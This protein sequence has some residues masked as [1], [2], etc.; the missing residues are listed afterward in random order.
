MS[1]SEVVFS[2][3]DSIFWFTQLA[4]CAPE[5]LGAAGAPGDRT[6][7]GD[8]PPSGA[9]SLSAFWATSERVR[10]TGPTS[11]GGAC[12]LM[13]LEAAAPLRQ[14]RGGWLPCDV[15]R[16]VDAHPDHRGRLAL[17]G[18]LEGEGLGAGGSADRRQLGA[19]GVLDA[20]DG[21]GLQAVG[22]DGDAWSP[23]ASMAIAALP[24]V[25]TAGSAPCRRPG[26]R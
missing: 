14:R 19:D 18:A 2:G 15:G 10:V 26:T 17:E 20:A 11:S 22:G 5:G 13:R 1:C 23:C 6:L 7:A 4:T 24:L 12:V 16:L 8:L 21:R 25:A 3:R 9:F